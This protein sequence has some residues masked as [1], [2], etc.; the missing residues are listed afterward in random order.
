MTSTQA[1]FAI[2]EL[3]DI[4]VANIQDDPQILYAINRK[5]RVASR[6]HIFREVTLGHNR[7]QRFYELLHLHPDIAPLVRILCITERRSRGWTLIDQLYLPRILEMLD[8]LTRVVLDTLGPGMEWSTLPSLLTTSLATTFQLRSSMISSVLLKNTRGVPLSLLFSMPALKCLDLSWITVDFESIEDITSHSNFPTHE[9]AS[10]ARP[11]ARLDTLNLFL[12]RD[13]H[14]L[15]QR[16]FL[17]SESPI[18]ISHLTTL[19]FMSYNNDPSHHLAYSHLLHSAKKHIKHVGLR[20]CFGT[21]CSSLCCQY[22]NC[23]TFQ[24]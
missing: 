11:R 14:E 6:S 3:V 19:N 8:K 5:F 9:P 24:E 1:F 15:V 16:L 23:S 18:D 22:T 21:Y 20:L 13:V 10:L 12:Q 17:S 4:V 7:C 2:Q